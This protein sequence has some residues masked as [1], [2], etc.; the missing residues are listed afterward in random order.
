MKWGRASN[1]AHLGG[2]EEW[3]SAALR[4]NSTGGGGGSRGPSPGGFGEGEKR[5]VTV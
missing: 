1:Q 4:G 2:R 3:V 5:A